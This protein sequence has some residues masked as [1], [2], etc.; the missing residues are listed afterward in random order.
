MEAISSFP[1]I[2]CC[3]KASYF[4]RLMVRACPSILHLLVKGIGSLD[5]RPTGVRCMAM[6]RQVQQD[7]M[8][9]KNAKHT[10][11]TSKRGC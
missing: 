11:I 10:E 4:L 7:G 3:L 5:C 8:G 9:S 2:Q 6:G 1:E